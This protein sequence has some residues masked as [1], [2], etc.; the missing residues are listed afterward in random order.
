MPFVRVSP[1]TGPATPRL[2]AAL[3]GELGRVTITPSG[4]QAAGQARPERKKTS[5]KEA[6]VK[7]VA[8]TIFID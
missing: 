5:F 3:R 4:L 6:Q 2:A 1:V 7:L 8:N